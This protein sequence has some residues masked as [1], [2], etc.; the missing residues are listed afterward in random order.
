MDICDDCYY[1]HGFD[2]DTD[3]GESEEFDVDIA[4]DG[5][6]ECRNYHLI[7]ANVDRLLR[8]IAADPECRRFSHGDEIVIDVE[9]YAD[10]CSRC[11]NPDPEYE[12]RAGLLGEEVSLCTDCIEEITSQTVG[13]ST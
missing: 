13:G 11:G 4:G 8:H 1:E 10:V 6:V 9:T 5:G 7:I 2:E 12:F 3:A